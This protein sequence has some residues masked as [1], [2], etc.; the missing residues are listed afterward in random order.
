MTWEID[1]CDDFW[2]HTVYYWFFTSIFCFAVPVRPISR[3]F[4]PDNGSSP[5]LLVEYMS[6]L[7]RVLMVSETH[8]CIVGGFI[9]VCPLIAKLCILTLENIDFNIWCQRRGHLDPLID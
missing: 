7:R 6:A 5:A 4:S 2:C 1:N 3:I 8:Y 9:I